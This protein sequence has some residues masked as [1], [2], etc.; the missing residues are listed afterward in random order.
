MSEVYVVEEK[1]SGNGLGIA[2]LVCGIVS[3]CCLNPLYLVSA[4]AIILGIVALCKK[5]ENKVMPIVGLCLGGGSLLL[6]MVVDIIITI[7]TMGA[8][9]F[10]FLI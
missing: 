7:C 8:G 10:S 4:A 6:G 1:K 9:F 2:A 3:F 5:G